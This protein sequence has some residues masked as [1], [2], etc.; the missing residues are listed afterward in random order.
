MAK[1]LPETLKVCFGR[2]LRGRREP[3]KG[4]ASLVAGAANPDRPGLA[5]HGAASRAV[6]VDRLIERGDRRSLAALEL[7]RPLPWGQRMKNAAYHW[8]KP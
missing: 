6:L 5:A 2:L 8:S 4:R 7:M 3:F 1:C